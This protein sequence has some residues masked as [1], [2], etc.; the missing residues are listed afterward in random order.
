MAYEASEIMMAAALMY[1]NEELN[2]YAKNAAGLKTLMFD[3]KKRI[4]STTNK[5]VQFGSSAIEKG[6]T[7][8]INP[9]N[10]EAV[11]DMAG[12][13][14]AAIG[15]RE[16]LSKNGESGGSRM[17]PTIYMT[18]NVW[19]KEV[20]KFRVSAYGF[21]DYNSADVIATADKKTFYGVSLKKKRKAAAGE[22]TLINKAFDSVLDGKQFDKI[23]QEL[24]EIRSEYFAGLVIE[25]V[26]KKIILKNHIEGFDTLKRTPQGRK[27][28]FESKKRD[29]KLFDRAYID[30]KGYA[31]HKQ[32]YKAD[33]TKDPRSMRYFVNKKLAEPDNPLW[34]EFLKVLNKYADLF[35]DSLINIILKVKLFEEIDAKD[36]GKYKFNFFLVTGVGDVS[37]KGDVTIGKA[38]VLPLKTTLCGLTRIN[39]MYKNKKYEIVLNKEKKGE[40]DAAKIFLQLKKGNLTLLDLEIRYKGAFTPQPQFQ[41]TLHPDFKQLLVDE[42][43]LE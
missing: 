22:P 21:E 26:E 1:S 16:Y 41:G 35:A 33:D 39:E 7:D 40:S 25:A 10:S 19:P 12:G 31:S 29:K 17:Y 18:G 13:I 28:L 8:L 6:F 23:K 5:N 38:T 27:E 4:K 43:G 3:A 36:L 30:T 14:S 24:A 2:E 37:T 11:K 20:E 32:G 42:C 9:N 34:K 15:L